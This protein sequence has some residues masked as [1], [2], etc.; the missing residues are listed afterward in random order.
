[1]TWMWYVWLGLF[2]A[3]EA[4]A[5]IRKRRG[6][7]KARTLTDVVATWRDVRFGSL[8]VGRYLLACGLL[9]LVG[10]FFGVW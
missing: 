2:A 4:W 10:H 9:W 1:M 3:L 7:A 6:D 8:D 5:V